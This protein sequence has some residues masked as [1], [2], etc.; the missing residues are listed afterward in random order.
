[1]TIIVN[2]CRLVLALTFIVSGY[3]KSIDPLGTQYK[4]QDYLA[5]IDMAGIVSPWV[6][7]IASVLL[8]AVEFSLG[9]F[10]LFAIRRLIVSRLV[11]LMMTVMTLLTVWIYFADPVKDCGCFGDAFVLT[12]GETLLKNIVLIACAAIVAWRPGKML[13]LISKSN[14]WIVMNYTCRQMPLWLLLARC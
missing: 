12:N 7:L 1:M 5:A 6:T 2:L 9:I 4:L 10:M 11:L 13:R 3:V 8:S 14:Q